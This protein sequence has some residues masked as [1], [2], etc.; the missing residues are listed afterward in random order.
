MKTRSAF[1]IF[2][3]WYQKMIFSFL[4]SQGSC[5]RPRGRTKR[6]VRAQTKI[7]C[8]F[9]LLQTTYMGEMKDGS[10]GPPVQPL[11]PMAAILPFNSIT[12][13]LNLIE[14]ILSSSMS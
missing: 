13:M 4:I 14:L 5:P 10:T 6:S 2:H 8:C 9:W 7:I 3:F 11:S 1:T 12:T